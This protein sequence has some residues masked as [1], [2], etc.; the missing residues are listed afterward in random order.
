M[1][2][3]SL[4]PIVKFIDT[5]SANHIGTNRVRA[6]ERSSFAG[7]NR[8]SLAA[9]CRFTFPAAHGHKCGVSVLTRLNPI[10]TGLQDGE[11]LIGRVHFKDLLA[12][13]P[14]HTNVESS[15][16]ELKLNC[17]VIQIEEGEACAAIQPDR[18]GTNA[19]FRA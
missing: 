19:Q 3:A 12:T 8:V 2:V 13:E 18:P 15:L 10:A 9:A 7:M 17:A 5:A 1:A 4:P 6:G 16:R 11:R 14:L